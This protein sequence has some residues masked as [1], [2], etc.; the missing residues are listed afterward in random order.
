MNSINFD[1]TLVSTQFTKDS[2][3]DSSKESSSE[4]N[5]PYTGKDSLRSHDD[6]QI[7]NLQGFMDFGAVKSDQKRSRRSSKNLG[8]EE[9]GRGGS[10]TK[11][12]SKYR[13]RKG[14][15]RLRSVGM[16]QEEDDVVLR[17]VDD[18]D[19]KMGGLAISKFLWG[20][21]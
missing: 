17:D 9:L 16:G 5:D 1:T 21:H 6:I 11:S 7:L 10:I 13:K 14:R 19:E 4:I 8:S 18:F 3:K 15:L 2:S 12:K 20:C